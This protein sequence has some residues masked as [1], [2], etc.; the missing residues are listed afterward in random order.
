MIDT[1]VSHLSL[2]VA[3]QYHSPQTMNHYIYSSYSCE[4]LPTKYKQQKWD[5]KSKPEKRQRPSV[6]K[7]INISSSKFIFL[8]SKLLCKGTYEWSTRISTSELSAAVHSSITADNWDSTISGKLIYRWGNNIIRSTGKDLWHQH[9]FKSLNSYTE[10]QLSD[11]LF[12]A[13]F[14]H[15]LEDVRHKLKGSHSNNVSN[16]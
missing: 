9:S 11:I 3:F 4:V 2:S 10:T 8:H 16:F 14:S 1:R 6:M 5:V 13:I 15:Y 12:C 7:C